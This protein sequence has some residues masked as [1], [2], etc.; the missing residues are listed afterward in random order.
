MVLV[1]TT[2]VRNP[3]SLKTRRTEG[4][5][6]REKKISS[7]TIIPLYVVAMVGGIPQVFSQ[8]KGTLQL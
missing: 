2:G 1:E 8:I 6:N 4:A 7:N 5:K 3:S